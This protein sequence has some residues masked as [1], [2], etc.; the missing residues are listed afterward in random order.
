MN[1]ELYNINLEYCNE[2]AERINTLS[3]AILALGN[4]IKEL[5]TK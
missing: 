1:E 5:E 2:L 3:D 4:R